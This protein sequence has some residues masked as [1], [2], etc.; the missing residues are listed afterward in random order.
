VSASALRLGVSGG[1]GSGKSTVCQILERQG[2][3]VIDAD[4]ISRASTAAGGS[5]IAAIQA[6]FGA[7]F[8]DTTGA[9]DR[10]QMRQ[11]VFSEPKAR[12]RLEAIVHPLIALEIERQAAAAKA[13][14]VRCIVFD[15]PLLVES[16]QWRKN[17]DRVLIVDCSAQTQLER[18]AQRSGL[19]EAEV[20]TIIAAQSTRANR[21]QAADIV[22]FNE[23]KNLFEIERELENLR[24]RFGL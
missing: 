9:M 15:I 7:D 18:V 8:V 16:R 19:S 6:S 24:S 11:L 4:A 20:Q 17:L 13:R 1:I 14:G 5:A 22:I 23:G 2:A 21:L 12:A 3:C 10:T